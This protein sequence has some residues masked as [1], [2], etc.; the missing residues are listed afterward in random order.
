MTW[1]PF[2]VDFIQGQ[3]IVWILLLI[4]HAGQDIVQAQSPLLAKLIFPRVVSNLQATC[5]DWQIN[6]P[7]QEWKSI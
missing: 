4:R 1:A 2:L 6:P 7:G 5:Q 3:G